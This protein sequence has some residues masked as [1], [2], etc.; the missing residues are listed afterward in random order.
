VSGAERRIARLRAALDA[1]DAATF[2]VTSPVNVRYLTGFESSNAAALI[3]ADRVILVT[4][5]RYIEVARAVEGVEVVESA[6]ELPP[7][8]GARLAELAEPPVAFEAAH[9]TYAAH[10]ALAASGLELR[11][12]PRVVEELRALKDGAE[13]DAIRRAARVTNAVYERL[14]SEEVVGTSE[15]E[16]AWRLQQALHDEGADEPAFPIIV[17]GGP[18]AA[19]PHHHAGRRP[20]ATGETLI[21]DLGAK[22]DGYSSD[23]TRTFATGALPDE[24]ERAYELCREAQAEALAAVRPGASAKEV[25]AIARR[26]I[27]AAG[28]E[29]LHGLGHGVGLDVHELPRLADTSEATLAVGNVV[30]V[31]PGVYLRGT[32]GVRIEDLVVVTEEGPEILT[33]VAKEVALLG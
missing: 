26:R 1:L 29:V 14:G 18:S 4:D 2:L 11:P 10:E 32:G 12:A 16:L 9:V 30:T 7:Y 24:L 8:L 5:G 20:I 31:E 19:L 3:G 17:A 21:V 33:P 13:L 25:D 6:R 15:A 27:T 28:H 23:C 22:L